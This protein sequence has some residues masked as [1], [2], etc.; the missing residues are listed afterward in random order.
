MEASEVTVT[1]LVAQE[2]DEYGTYVDG[3]PEAMFYHSVAHLRFLREL[4]GAHWNVMLARDGE[5]RIV[6]VLPGMVRNGA[7][8]PVMNSLP[9]YGSNGGILASTAG[10]IAALAAAWN[11]ASADVLSA[12]V[13]A[14]PLAADDPGSR[15]VHDVEDR[16]IGQFSDIGCAG[17]PAAVLMERF[18]SKTRN[19]VR[20][21]QKQGFDVTIDDGALDFLRRV[22]VENLAALGGRRKSDAF[23]DL[24]PRHFVA[25]TQFRLW[26]ASE[27]GEP[28]AALLLFYFR[29]TVEYYMPTVRAAWRDRQPLSLLIFEA[30]VDASRRGYRLWNWGGTWTSQDGVYHFKKRWGARDLPYTYY[31]RINDKSLLK[32]GRETLL[33]EYPDFFVIPF[34]LLDEAR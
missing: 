28:V 20:K 12:T 14:N 4:L 5:G 23:F 7:L 8:G 22:H 19:I 17:D 16:R 18:H 13:V 32:A 27:A 11:L 25:G 15:L 10:G 34:N 24:V 26:V 9:H 1:R 31:T 21:A 3:H 30:M 6:G 33:R 2:E 29:D